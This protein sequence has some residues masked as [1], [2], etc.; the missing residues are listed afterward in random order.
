PRRTQHGQ[1]EATPVRAGII[2]VHAADLCASAQQSLLERSEVFVNGTRDSCGDECNRGSWLCHQ[3]AHS[4]GTRPTVNWSPPDAGIWTFRG[5]S[6]GRMLIACA[7]QTVSPSSSSQ[8][9]SC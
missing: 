7:T 3:G 8:P 2:P 6:T 5:A 9:P 4:S 1:I